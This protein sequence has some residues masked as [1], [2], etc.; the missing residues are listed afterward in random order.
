MIQILSLLFILLHI[1][2]HSEA[3]QKPLVAVSITPYAG[4]LSNVLEGIADVHVCV[5]GSMS[6]HTWEPKP[7]DLIAMKKA[8]LWFASGEPFESKLLNALQE[9]KSPIRF[10]DLRDGVEILHGNGCC[11][12]HGIDPHI[13]LSP[14]RLLIQLDHIE[15]ALKES[16]PSSSSLIGKRTSELKAAIEA[17]H[18]ELLTSL[19]PYKGTTLVVAHHAYAYFC[20]E[21]HL[22]ELPI[23][24]EGKEMNIHELVELLDLAKKAHVHTVFTQV[25]YPQ[26]AAEQIA[27]ELQA[28]LK[29][30]NPYSSE[31]LSMMYELQDA[32]K[33]E[34]AL[35]KE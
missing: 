31:Y 35:Q 7:H 20:D 5:P 15:K 14:P 18:K 12:H 22:K 2:L 24:H 1:P 26:K 27:K 4:L 16:F 28:S 6:A 11:S 33:R 30:L 3:A 21:Y 9:E 19:A 10:I 34:G 23:E 17:L 13:W 29:E 8:L 25:Q 32:F